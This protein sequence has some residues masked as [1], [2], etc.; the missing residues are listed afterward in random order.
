MLDTTSDDKD[1]PRFVTK[2][3]I[4][5]YYQSVKHYDVNKEIRIKTPMFRTDLC[6]F[7]DVYIVMKGDVTVTNLDNA[8]RLKAVAFKNNAPFINCISKMNGVQIDN[9]KT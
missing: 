9:E 5:V 1:L 3:L 4:E 7:S 8:K 6:D 2:K